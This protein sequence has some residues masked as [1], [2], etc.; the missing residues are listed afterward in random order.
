[1]RIHIRRTASQSVAVIFAG[2]LLP[3][4]QRC[5]PIESFRVKFASTQRRSSMETNRQ[6]ESDDIKLR[7]RLEECL[8]HARELEERTQA[9]PTLPRLPEPPD[10]S[11]PLRECFIPGSILDRKSTRLNSSHLGIS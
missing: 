4:C 3:P 5:L 2:K 1:M 9:P 8:R 7:Q 10:L 11:V 6:P